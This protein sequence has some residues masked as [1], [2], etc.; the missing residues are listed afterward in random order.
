M[1]V[2]W[3]IAVHA[4]VDPENGDETQIVG[5]R[6]MLYPHEVTAIFNPDDPTRGGFVINHYA[7]AMLNNIRT[8]I[9]EKFA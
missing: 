2:D 7:T 9:E 1:N 3:I 6:R 8:A 4:Y 5:E